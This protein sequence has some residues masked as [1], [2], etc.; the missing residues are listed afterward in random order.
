[1]PAITR[2]VPTSPPAS[3]DHPR[4]RWGLA[5]SFVGSL[6]L[7][8]WSF[9][10]FPPV[11]GPLERYLAFAV[12]GGGIVCGAIA[13]GLWATHPRPQIAAIALR[14]G[15]WF[16]GLCA[17]LWIAYILGTHLALAD[18]DKPTVGRVLTLSLFGAEFLILVLLSGYTAWQT[19]DWWSGSQIGLWTGLLV[20]LLSFGTLLLLLYSQ[21]GFLVQHMNSGE[22]A[23]F[24]Q[25]GRRDRMTWFFWEEEFAGSVGYFVPQLVLAAA[26]GGLGVALGRAV[27]VVRPPVQPGSGP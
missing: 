13:L 12:G 7:V 9:V 1:M 22:L 8:G 20:G 18:A 27:A 10:R 11:E 3:L 24:A 21:M 25:S 16:G 19:C 17:V 26:C 5:G 6:L 15:V 2:L 23:A 14:R 4:L